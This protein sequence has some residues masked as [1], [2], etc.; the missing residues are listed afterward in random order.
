MIRGN[1]LSGYGILPSSRFDRIEV[2]NIL[3]VN[4]VGIRGVL[5]NWGPLLQESPAATIVGYFMN[6]T[7]LEEDGDATMA[8]DQRAIEPIFD[9]L[10]KKMKVR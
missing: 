10:M 8:K 1:L 7:V 5:T 4:Y 9:S 3:D 6:W 2:S